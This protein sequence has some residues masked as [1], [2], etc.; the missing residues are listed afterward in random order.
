[1]KKEKTLLIGMNIFI[2]AIDQ[3]VKI[4]MEKI[5]KIV[6]IPGVLNFEVMQNSNAAYGVGSN[7]TIMYVLTNVVILGTILKFMT[8]QNQ[9]VD[10]KLKLFLNFILAG[11]ISNVIDRILRGYVLEFIDFRQVIPLP[12]WNIADICI[13]IGWIA[14][15]AIFASFTVKEWR[16]KKNH[17]KEE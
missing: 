13:L 5:E 7:S 9:F 6:I 16:N 4:G 15:A 10:L 1:M 12:V 17:S 3:L 8:T 2:I 11:G 14:M